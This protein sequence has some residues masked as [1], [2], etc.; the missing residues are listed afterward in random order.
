[1][2]KL[3]DKKLK[4]FI[5]IAVI[6]LAGAAAFWFFLF[7]DIEAFKLLNFKSLNSESQRDIGV[8]IGGESADMTETYTNQKYG[9]SFNHSKEFSVSEFA[10][11]GRDIVLAKDATASG[12]FQILIS[13]FD[14][15]GPITKERILKD[16]P[17]MSISNEKEILV[18]GEK[19][20]SF[21][22]KDESGE[23]LEIWFV[24]FG[25]LYQISA[26]PSFEKQMMEI[27]SSWRFSN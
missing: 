2:Q 12:V 27:L 22:S 18:G 8:P 3:S 16:I 4:I 20:L 25:N 26:L 1:M 11:G 7:R 21:K 23:T 24:R 15:P 10:E 6:A 17:N 5:A 13:P 14:E 19:A 9:F